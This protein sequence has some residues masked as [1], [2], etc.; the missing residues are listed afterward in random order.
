MYELSIMT[1]NFEKK[2]YNIFTPHDLFF[3]FPQKFILCNFFSQLKLENSNSKI[4][5]I[6]KELYSRRATL[7]PFLQ[8]L[9]LQQDA[10]LISNESGGQRDVE[11]SSSK[12]E[13]PTS[14][15]TVNCKPQRNNKSKKNKRNH[16]HKHK[17]I[18][19]LKL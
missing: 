9:F 2:C 11:E 5:S 14:K 10:N 15:A 13:K 17:Q 4:G 7:K 19:F 8:Q 6:C 16:D 3:V 12:S 18:A 1:S